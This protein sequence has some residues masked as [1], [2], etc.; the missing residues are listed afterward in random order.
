M[1]ELK[2][3]VDRALAHIGVLAVVLVHDQRD[4]RVHLD[5]GLDQVLDERLAR[6]FA[7]AGAGLQ[8]H[9]RAR[10]PWQPP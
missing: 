2:A 9:R 3:Q 10:F 5:S 4:A 8:D 1:T 6:V 7:C